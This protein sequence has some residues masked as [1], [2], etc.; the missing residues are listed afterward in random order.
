MKDRFTER[1]GKKNPKVAIQIESMDKDLR[2]GLWNIFTSYVWN[3]MK[4]DSQIYENSPNW[5]SAC[6]QK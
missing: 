2:N 4:S 1:I 5:H 3:P 6:K